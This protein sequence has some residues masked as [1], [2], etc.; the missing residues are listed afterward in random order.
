[1]VRILRERASGS[2]VYI[3]ERLQSKGGG[4][5]AKTT[6]ELSKYVRFMQAFLILRYQRSIEV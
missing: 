1:M 2:R 4:M 5:I 3:Q 6:Y